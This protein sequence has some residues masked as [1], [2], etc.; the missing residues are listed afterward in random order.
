MR[1]MLQYLDEE[2][3]DGDKDEDKDNDKLTFRPCWWYGMY[4]TKWWRYS[5]EHC[6]VFVFEGLIVL[7]GRET[8]KQAISA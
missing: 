1:T 8:H 5:S 2:E 6:G 7:Q 3:E 4:Y